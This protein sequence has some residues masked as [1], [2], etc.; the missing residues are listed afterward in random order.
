[1]FTHH[2]CPG[3]HETAW[4]RGQELPYQEFVLTA[5]LRAGLPSP[6]A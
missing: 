5:P 1:M 3:D 6:L 2:A 4:N